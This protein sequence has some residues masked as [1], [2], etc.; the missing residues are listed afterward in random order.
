MGEAVKSRK[1]YK[2]KKK[3]KKFGQ[4]AKNFRHRMNKGLNKNNRD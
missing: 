3:V 2:K 1:V 4:R